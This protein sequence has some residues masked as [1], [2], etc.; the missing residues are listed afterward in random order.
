[1]NGRQLASAVAA[2]PRSVVEGRFERH[3]SLG[4]RDLSGSDSGGRWGPEG[5]YSVLYLGRPQDSVIVEAYRHLVEPLADQGMTGDMVAPRRV[6]TC[7]VNLTN[8]LDLRTPNA[9]VSLGLSETDLLSAVGDYDACREVGRVAHQLE[10][11]GIIAPAATGLGESL[12]LFERHLPADELPTLV[13][14][15]LWDGL[16]AD[17]RR[18]RVV[19]G[20]TG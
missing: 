4:R 17:P 18:L 1:M 9:W 11:H 14:H 19:R 5:A 6:V 16:P 20:D 7:T 15:A 3:F 8:I 10:L 12:A 2:A 13:G